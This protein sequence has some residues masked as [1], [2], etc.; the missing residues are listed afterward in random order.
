[1]NEVKDIVNIETLAE[2]MKAF[3]KV[4]VA[5]RHRFTP[6]MY[7]R[8]VTMPTGLLVV[9]MK[10]LTEHPFVISK[11]R[12]KV[13]SENEGAVIYEAPYTGITQADTQR[14]LLILEETVWTTFHATDE[15][16]VEKIVSEITEPNEDRLLN[17]WRDSLP[18]PS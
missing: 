15:T 1:M 12:V 9:S 8:E 2:S 11:G 3:E 6:G 10:H 18:W 14:A 5:C 13:F 17:Q 7:I 16:D 4:D